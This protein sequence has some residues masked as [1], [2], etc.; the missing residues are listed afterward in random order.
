MTAFGK[1]ILK[2]SDIRVSQIKT[3]L[4]EALEQAQHNLSASDLNSMKQEVYRFTAGIHQPSELNKF[5][6]DYKPE[7]R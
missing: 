7:V 1:G 3:I 5:I 6:K 2:Q 4:S